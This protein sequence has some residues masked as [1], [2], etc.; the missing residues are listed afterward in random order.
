MFLNSNDQNGNHLSHQDSELR[1]CLEAESLS[2]SSVVLDTSHQCQ[3]KM[4]YGV[5]EWG[6]TPVISPPPGSIQFVPINEF[7]IRLNESLDY[8]FYFA[9]KRFLM[10]TY[11]PSI[12]P[13]F[14]IKIKKNS[15]KGYLVLEVVKHKKLNRAGSPCEESDSYHY[16][17]C[18][19]KT[20]AASVGCQTFWTD[21]DG[22]P[23]CRTL[24]QI[25]NFSAEY[26]NTILMEQTDIQRKTGCLLPSVHYQ[27]KV[28][29]HYIYYL[30]LLL[31]F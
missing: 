18:I 9:D 28:L 1:E 26:R 5:E 8:V 11:N 29:L 27:Y 21:F 13:Q 2:Y 16:A 23:V 19:V 3:H 12:L 24:E 30:N 20:T 6:L 22:I 10:I 15:G 7:S 4:F 31:I 25:V 17:D 14:Y